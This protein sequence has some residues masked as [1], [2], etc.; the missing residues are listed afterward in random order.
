MDRSAIAIAITNHYHRQPDALD[1]WVAITN[2]RMGL[3]RAFAEWSF[4]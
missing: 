4:E 1:Q 2:A 3:R